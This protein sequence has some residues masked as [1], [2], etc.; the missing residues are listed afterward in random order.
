L[1]LSTLILGVLVTNSVV[2]NSPNQP[3]NQQATSISV[4]GSVKTTGANTQP[5]QIIFTNIVTRQ[6]TV[7]TTGTFDCF[8]NVQNCICPTNCAAGSTA[9][10][11]FNSY[12]V[13]LPN[14]STYKVT[15][16]WMGAF[17]WQGGESNL[18]NFTLNVAPYSGGVSQDFTVNTPDSWVGITGTISLTGQ[19]VSNPVPQNITFL[20]QNLGGIALNRNNPRDRGGSFSAIIGPSNQ[21]SLN[22]PNYE[23]YD[24][25]I[26]WTSSSG[27]VSSCHNT[28]YSNVSCP[29]ICYI[30]M[31]IGIGFLSVDVNVGNG[32]AYYTYNAS[33]TV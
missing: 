15:V 20:S 12:T 5:S 14:H 1:L 18:G 21:Y 7:A 17:W 27:T 8:Y 24:I 33:C 4:S 13:T 26:S 19:S 31:P 6:A 22:I 9:G 10:I 30:A 25:G 11:L 2:N 16:L 32:G 23:S 29:G 28:T 3:V